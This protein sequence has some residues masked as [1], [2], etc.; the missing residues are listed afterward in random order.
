VAAQ[1]TS[2]PL[3]VTEKEMLI[4]LR[5]QIELWRQESTSAVQ[6]LTGITQ[7][8]ITTLQRDG[9]R[10]QRDID[11]VAS[12]A[13][14]TAEKDSVSHMELWSIAVGSG[15]ILSVIAGIIAAVYSR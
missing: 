3:A 1:S 4:A 12:L 13:R 10:R 9:E 11:A 6:A 8:R 7:E 5:G 14:E 2:D 15:T